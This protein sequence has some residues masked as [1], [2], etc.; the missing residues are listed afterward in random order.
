MAGAYFHGGKLSCC[1]TQQELSSLSSS[2]LLQSDCILAFRD[3]PYLPVN[4]IFWH[5]VQEITFSRTKVCLLVNHR[6]AVKY[7]Y[8]AVITQYYLISEG[9][10]LAVGVCKE[11]GVHTP[12]CSTEGAGNNAYK[13]HREPEWRP[14][15]G[16][17]GLDS[18]MTFALELNYACVLDFFTQ[19]GPQFHLQCV[20]KVK[21]SS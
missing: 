1:I 20:F 2:E 3:S 21:K 12:A 19:K 18:R 14:L 11:R 4:W 15:Q 5:S 10:C 17:E 8:A 13:C 6:S 7:N 9:G 16:F